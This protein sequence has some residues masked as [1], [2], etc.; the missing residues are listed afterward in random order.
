MD[1]GKIL[2]VIDL[3]VAF[4]TRRGVV[5]AAKDVG[6]EL[7]AGRTLGIVGESGS[8]KSVSALSVMRLLPAGK[9]RLSGQILL[10]DGLGGTSLPLHQ[11]G[12]RE[13]Q[14]IRGRRIGMIFQEPMSSLNPVFRCGEQVAES[15]R[16]HLKLEAKAAADRVLE[17]F[18]R[19]QLSDPARIFKSFPHQ[20]SGGQKQRVMIAMALCCQPDLLIADEPTTALDVTVQKAILDLIRELQNN[21]GAA[22]LFI[23]HDLGVISELAHDVAVMHQ[24][25]VVETGPVEEVFRHPRHPYTKGLIACRPPLH[26]RLHRL[27][28]VA[29]FLS[30]ETTVPVVAEASPRIIDRR[31]PLIDVRGVSVRYPGR[32]PVQALSDASFVLY[33]GETMGIVGESGSGKTTLGRAL[34]RLVDAQSGEVWYQGQ[35]LMSLSDAP[36]RAF[37]REIQMIFQDPYSALNPRHTIGRAI[38]EPMQWHGISL[39]SAEGKEQTIELLLTVG[40]GPEYFD[41]YPHELSGGQRQRACIARALSVQPRLLICDESVSALDVSVQAQVLNLLQD[42]RDSHGLSMIFI[43]HDIS[44][45]RQISDRVL[46]MKDGLIVESGTTD[47]VCSRPQ[48]SYTRQ[49]MAAVPGKQRGA[50]EK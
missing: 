43:S 50:F 16:L 38:M 41:R 11:F 45:I 7:H 22:C 34:L 6:F 48:S 15:L 20:L 40:L 37:R 29:D 18:D 3:N 24:G 2:E 28:V 32:P 27:P 17:W 49:L 25:V 14:G 46:V 30:S 8:G 26:K 39:S 13:M 5:Q 4:A 21:T 19:V 47:E 31:T 9:C 10:S 35:N 1:K 23:S 42:L 33:P 44:V 36:L 12:E